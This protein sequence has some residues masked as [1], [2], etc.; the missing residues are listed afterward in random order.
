MQRRELGK[1]GLEVSI[2]GLGA[3][4]IGNPELSEAE[5]ARLLHG[6]LDLGIN[7]VDTAR[8]YGLSEERI[9]RHLSAR[10]QDFVL[11]TKVGYGV[12]GV[13]DWTPE[14]IRLGIDL[15]LETLRTDR[16]DVVHLHSCPLDVLREAGVVE[17]LGRAVEAGKVR[18]AAY[19]GENEALEWAVN[20]GE[21]GS[22]ECSVNFCDQRVIR[23]L[24]PRA[25]GREIGVIA[26]RPLANA[27][28]RH[29][30]CPR[31]DDRAEEE[32]WWRWRTM[33]LDPRGLAFSE[34]GLR[35]AAFAP[36]VASTIVGTRNI[37]HLMDNVRALESGPLPDEVRAEIERSFIENDPG[38]WVGQI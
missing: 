1:T 32:Y 35:F 28:W 8:G 11:S 20:S 36:G 27:V 37:Q 9:G 30:E 15:A 34:L 13:P 17:A 6:A 2:L 18:V 38:W 21:F 7:L 22:I 33:G 10:R 4:Q 25:A 12:P 23:D 19:S 14:C 5:A 24:F 16:L 26:K 3:G 31:G 29:S